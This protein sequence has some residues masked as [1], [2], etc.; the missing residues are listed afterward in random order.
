M[1]GKPNLTS[2]SPHT[3]HL[4]PFSVSDTFPHAHLKIDLMTPSFFDRFEPGAPVSWAGFFALLHD[5]AAGRVVL[6]AVAA[7]FYV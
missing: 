6:S 7:I 1:D 4:L 2:R 3:G 5:F